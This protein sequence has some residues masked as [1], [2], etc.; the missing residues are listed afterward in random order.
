[1]P[2]RTS[3]PKRPIFEQAAES[4]VESLLA[5]DGIAAEK[6]VGPQDIVEWA[7]KN[8]YIDSA[9]VNGVWQRWEKP[10]VLS[11][12]QKE[13][14]S[15]IWP[16]VMSGE[17]TLVVWSE[18]KKSGKT[19]IQALV[20]QWWA[21]QMERYNEIL[22]VA[23]DLEQAASHG[24]AMLIRSA[25]MNPEDHYSIRHRAGDMVH[26]VRRTVVKAI[27]CDFK[28]E[29]GKNQGL[30][31]WDELW[32]YTSEASQRLWDELTPPPTR[33]IAIRFV[34]TYAGFKGESTLLWDI[35]ESIVGHPRIHKEHRV[36]GTDLPI[37]QKGGTI[38][39]WS[40]E[41]R[42]LWQTAR[43]YAQQKDELR[44]TAFIRLHKNEWVQKETAFI[45]MELWDEC[46]NPEAKRWSPGDLRP[47]VIAID[48]SESLDCTAMAATYLD[49]ETGRLKLLEHGIWSPMPSD[50]LQGRNIVDLVETVQARVLELAEAGAEIPLIV[51]DPFQMSTIALNLAKK[52]FFVRPFSQ[53]DPRIKADTALF[54]NI[55]SKNLDVYEDSRDLR[56]HIE[57]AVKKE[58][59]KG[60]R[61]SK[62][63][64]TKPCDGAVA[65]SMSAFAAVDPEFFWEH[66]GAEGFMF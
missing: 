11:P 35:Y 48:A 31:L 64:A 61:I 53:G 45:P 17:V 54:L 16:K 15:I 12:Y 59:E 2:K 57:N 24:F 36:P 4:L 37:Y 65:L 55:T 23:N 44:P 6:D 29:A 7:E 8:F 56:E 60:F 51:Y 21:E 39:F 20:G 19:T 9:Y 34:V 10:I 28:G 14:F 46:V 1:M 47:L 62:D 42:Q 58:A 26:K 33:N 66:G 25:E 13:A 3:A 32:G 49:P 5:D 43:Y 18:P 27:P 41:P 22:F 50:L 38:V 63:K 30:S 40:H 52:G